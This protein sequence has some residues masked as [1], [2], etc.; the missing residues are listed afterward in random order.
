VE[1]AA[2]LFAVTVK[3]ADEAPAA[4][5]TLAGTVATAMFELERATT[6]PPAGATVLRVTVAVTVV[7]ERALGAARVRPLRAAAGVTSSA[8]V[9]VSAPSVAESVTDWRLETGRVETVKPA[10]EA[11]CGTAT[12]AGMVATARLELP[13]DTS[14]PPAGAGPL[15]VTVPST[16]LPPTALT[17]L[18]V[19]EESVWP[20]SG[21][22]KSRHTKDSERDQSLPVRTAMPILVKASFH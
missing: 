21:A 15:S 9:R 2:T 6:M 4:T 13:S 14:V 18:T 17:G 20:A 19:R 11:P 5:V 3:L 1:V 16:P 8:A 22:P 12:V 7:A 10:A